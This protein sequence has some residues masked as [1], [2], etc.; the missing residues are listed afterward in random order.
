MPPRYGGDDVVAI[1]VCVTKVVAR[2]AAGVGVCHV[3]ED[4]EVEVD[5][6][7][8]VEDGVWE[9]GDGVID[10]TVEVWSAVDDG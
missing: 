8:S 5:D 1:T 3:S 10:E 6:G 9:S 2:F 7:G 4:V